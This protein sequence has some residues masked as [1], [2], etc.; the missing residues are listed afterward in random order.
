[1][2][3]NMAGKPKEHGMSMTLKGTLANLIE[4]LVRG[5]GKEIYVNGRAYA[6][7]EKGNLAEGDPLRAAMYKGLE[8]QLRLSLEESCGVRINPADNKKISLPIYFLKLSE[9]EK[10]PSPDHDVGNH[11]YAIIE[12]T[13][14]KVETEGNPREVGIK[15]DDALD[16]ARANIIKYSEITGE[17]PNQVELYY[18]IEKRILFGE[19]E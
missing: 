1:M 10:I 17:M 8:S 7:R 5:R 13:R 19:A 6:L 11:R 18:G 12:G 9:A 2:G 3:N 15:T 14:Y 4:T 16:Q